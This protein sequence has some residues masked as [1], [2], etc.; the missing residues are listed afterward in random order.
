MA[1]AKATNAKELA[2]F[3]MLKPPATDYLAEA[4]SAQHYAEILVA[5]GHW[6]PALNYLAHAMPSREGVWWAWYCA[7]KAHSKDQQP[8][9]QHALGLAEKWIAQ[10]TEE[11]RQIAKSYAEREEAKA[12][13]QHVLEAIVA[14]GDLEDA[15]SGAKSPPP[16]YLASKFVYAATVASAYPP[17]PENPAET[18]ADYLRQGFDVA[19]RIQ[20]WSQYK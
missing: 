1:Q 19:N 5:K 16:N 14:T 4:K 2:Q 13:P 7:R 15:S 8:E 17:N 10:P 20:L 6:M 3:A 11:N 18:A 9:T 12:A